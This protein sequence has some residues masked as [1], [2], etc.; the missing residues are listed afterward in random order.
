M[1]EKIK[2]KTKRT[3]MVFPYREEYISANRKMVV[4]TSFL[5]D[6]RNNKGDFGNRYVCIKTVKDD[7]NMIIDEYFTKAEAAPENAIFN[8]AQGWNEE[9]FNKFLKSMK[10]K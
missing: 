10:K 6:K 5:L 7:T 9:S 3:N 8:V 2:P 4:E 1:N